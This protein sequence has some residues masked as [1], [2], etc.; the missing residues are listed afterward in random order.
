MRVITSTKIE[1]LVEKLA[2]K[3]NIVLRK[4]IL[5]GLKTAYK[6]EK[7][8]LSKM[9]LSQIIENAQLAIKEK[10]AICQDT[11]LPLVFVEL[12]QGVSLRGK[13]LEDSINDG[14][15][16]AYKKANFRASIIQD[17]LR[18]KKDIRFT[19]VVI[20]TKIKAGNKV[21]LTVMPKGF[22][23]ENVSQ[24]KMFKPT[25]GE[26]KIIDFVVESVKKAGAAACP[27][28]II[29]LGIG[30]SLDEALILSKKALL[31]NIG[32]SNRSYKLASLEKGILKEV[33]KT[34]LGPMGFGGGFT[35]LGVSIEVA[36]THIAGLPVAVSLGC[37]AT[38]S[39]SATI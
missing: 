33:N 9:A 19:P 15:K 39:A 18:D 35:A 23:S 14:I 1:K 28:F 4:D 25:A 22:G 27:P 5:K 20:H 11:G 2:I 16:K 3:A 6:K 13:S 7:R 24:V 31:R 32:K 34:R 26:K 8:P 29:G 36:P 30:G 17:P 10:L 21:R 37:H 38:R 12:G